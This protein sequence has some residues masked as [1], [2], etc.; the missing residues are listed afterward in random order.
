MSTLSCSTVEYFV[1]CL[2][3][4]PIC[5]SPRAWISSNSN[6]GSSVF[7][8][9]L[10]SALVTTPWFELSRIRVVE[11][12]MLVLANPLLLDK[13]KVAHKNCKGLQDLHNLAANQAMKTQ[14]NLDV[15]GM[16]ALKRMKVGYI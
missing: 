9:C 1:S 2:A 7:S 10:A 14:L 8:A 11:K 16:D 12:Y 3:I 5:S 6:S 15:R 4:W 13:V